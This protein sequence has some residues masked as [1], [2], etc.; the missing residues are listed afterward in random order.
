MA[1]S[2]AQDRV[3]Q[4]NSIGF[5]WTSKGPEMPWEARF[6]ELV[7]YKANHGDCNISTKQGQLGKW[8][9]TQRTN[10]R[11]GKL[12]QDR[13]DRLSNIGFKWAL[14]EA[15]STV[16][17][18]TRFNELV[19]YKAKHGDC[20]VPTKQGKLGT[21]VHTQRI[22][23]AAGS[24]AQDRTDQLSSIGFEWKQRDPT[25][26]WETRFNELVQYKAKHGD[27]DVP[28][29]Q[30]QLGRWVHKQRTTHKKGK[31][32]RDRIDRLTGIGFD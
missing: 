4:L 5:K 29:S 8:V 16:P 6:K 25:V 27:C 28:W 17:W 13:I 12:S 10:Y 18:E 15:D 21:W 22:A 30:G 19:Q 20:N 1:G 14:K 9:G 3:D 7:Q 2:F 23:Y 26:P 24:L 31:L 32:S 11:K